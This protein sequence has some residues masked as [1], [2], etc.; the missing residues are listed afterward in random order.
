M[1]KIPYPFV[2]I[3]GILNQGCVV[4]FTFELKRGC[5]R[6]RQKRSQHEC[7]NVFPIFSCTP[8][9]SVSSHISHFISV[10]RNS[11]LHICNIA[12]LTRSLSGGSS[13]WAIHISQTAAH[14]ALPFTR[15]AVCG[16]GG[17]P[18]TAGH[19]ATRKERFVC[20]TT[21]SLSRVSQI[22][23]HIVCRSGSILHVCTSAPYHMGTSS[24]TVALN[25]RI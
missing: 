6:L 15:F 9:R 11:H 17:M 24:C 25:F 20:K 19:P 21:A 3:N 18:S 12:D 13:V 16:R 1:I 8:L 7:G 14:A 23:F 5:F 22:R 4:L 10:F 2:K